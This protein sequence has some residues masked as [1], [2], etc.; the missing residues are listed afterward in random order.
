MNPS[1][2]PNGPV[3]GEGPTAPPPPPEE[4]QTWHARMFKAAKETLLEYDRKKLSKNLLTQKKL[5][6]ARLAIHRGAETRRFLDSEFWKEFLQPAL[7]EEQDLKPWKPGDARS[8][9]QVAIDHLF[10]SGKAAISSALLRKFDDWI[11]VGDEAKKI[12]AD[13]TATEDRI[14]ELSA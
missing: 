8:M 13:N 3:E 5:S 9:E 1:I 14:R 11:R 4:F 6:D 10:A 12:V 2:G 7:G